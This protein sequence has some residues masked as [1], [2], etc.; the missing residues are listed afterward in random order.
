MN[1]SPYRQNAGKDVQLDS[2]S[3][4][5]ALILGVIV[6]RGE[7]CSG[8]TAQ[9]VTAI[10]RM[11]LNPASWLSS[12]ASAE[13]QTASGRLHPLPQAVTSLR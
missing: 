2:D 8:S 1:T 13:W 9:Q 11:V 5:V 6:A 4:D 7:P 12:A 3:S 10:A